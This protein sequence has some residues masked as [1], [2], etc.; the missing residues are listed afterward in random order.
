MLT[1]KKSLLNGREIR[2]IDEDGFLTEEVLEIVY[3]ILQNL[4]THY[5]TG[6]CIIKLK[7]QRSDMILISC[8]SSA[9]PKNSDD[10]GRYT[11][12]LKQWQ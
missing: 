6:E 2:K 5:I 4:L 7:T 10:V 11:E 12:I 8:R 3:H 1:A 9:N